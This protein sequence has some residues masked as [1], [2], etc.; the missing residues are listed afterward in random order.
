[1]IYRRQS[2]SGTIHVLQRL[3]FLTK[4]MF[5]SSVQLWT[6]SDLEI[7]MNYVNNFAA[8]KELGTNV[9]TLCGKFT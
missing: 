9:C 2:N 3:V 4:G 7:Y 5:F 6:V 1:M 8:N